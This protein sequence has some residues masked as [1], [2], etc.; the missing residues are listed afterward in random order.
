M[1]PALAYSGTYPSYVLCGTPESGYEVTRN[2]GVG[3][4]SIVFRSTT[5]DEAVAYLREQDAARIWDWTRGRPEE[6]CP[7]G[8]REIE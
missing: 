6:W 2:D 4:K 5:R 1:I 7:V 3:I 8:W